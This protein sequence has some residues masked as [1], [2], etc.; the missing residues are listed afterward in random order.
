MARVNYVK[1]PVAGA[2]R[3]VCST[4]TM[5]QEPE[6][7]SKEPE[8]RRQE[9]NVDCRR[10]TRH[11]IH[12]KYFSVILWQHFDQNRLV[13][14]H[15]IAQKHRTRILWQSWRPADTGRSSISQRYGCRRS[16]IRC[17]A[18]SGPLSAPD[19]RRAD[20]KPDQARPHRTGRRRARSHRAALAEP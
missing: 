14:G 11:R 8:D 10:T 7:G 17:S 12:L 5:S 4:R 3:F 2:S 15:R 16:V 1:R 19:R 18:L 6:A 20:A 9:S 13:F